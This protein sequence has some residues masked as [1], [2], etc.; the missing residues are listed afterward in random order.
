MPANAV[1]RLADALSTAAGINP[2]VKDTLID[3]TWADEILLRQK[4]VYRALGA[5]DKVSVDRFGGG[6][7]WNGIAAAKLLEKVLRP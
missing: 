2:V 6:H 4:R 5:D 3:A 1:D 7:R